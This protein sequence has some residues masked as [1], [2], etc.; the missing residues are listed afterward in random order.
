M[1]CN[2]TKTLITLTLLILV[3]SP[4]S[5]AQKKTVTLNVK[6]TCQQE[7]LWA[8]R[9]AERILTRTIPDSR[10]YYRI[11]YYEHC[12]C[13]YIIDPTKC[14]EHLK[15]CQ[16]NADKEALSYIQSVMERCK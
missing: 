9:D 10:G 11:S 8:L 2:L 16:D 7:L 12:R 4:F 13:C 6:P 5:P 1:T 14:K 3:S 15:K